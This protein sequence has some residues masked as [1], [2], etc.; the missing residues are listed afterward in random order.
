MAKIA[1]GLGDELANSRPDFPGA[2]SPYVILNHCLGVM[3][4]WGGRVIAGR[5]I[6]RDRDA[7]L[8]ATG[9]VR[10]LVERVPEQTE[11]RRRPEW[12]RS[13]SRREERV[14][15]AQR[16]RTSD[17]K[18]LGC[19]SYRRGAGAASRPYGDNQGRTSELPTQTTKLARRPEFERKALSS[20]VLSSLV[21][22]CPA[23]AF[24][25]CGRPSSAG[26]PYKAQETCP[27]PCVPEH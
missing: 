17:L 21:H 24:G 6:H 4:T 11:A 13:G 9:L 18:R 7:E 12:R 2:N 1:L 20:T 23:C 14:A 19:H 5:E 15:L 25:G 26:R 27:R 10:N 16:R 8:V 3:E 22:D